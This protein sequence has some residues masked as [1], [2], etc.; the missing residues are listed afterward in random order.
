[1]FER[2]DKVLARLNI[3]KELREHIEQDISAARKSWTMTPRASSQASDTS[4]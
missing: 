2:D 3:P 1:V 4:T